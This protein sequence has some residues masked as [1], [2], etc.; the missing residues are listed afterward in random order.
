MIF[1]TTRRA[2]K[3]TEAKSTPLLLMLAFAVTAS[4]L[5]FDSC[6]K[7]A[8]IESRP[9]RSVSTA[10]VVSG[11]FAIVE[12][13]SA[14]IAANREIDI[15]PKVGGR[16]HTVA[17][18][19][20]ETVSAAQILFTI[21]PGDCEAQYRQAAAALQSA[22]A[23][24]TRT[25]DAGQEQQVIQAQAAVDMAHAAYSDAKSL[26]DKTK[27]L[28]DSGA[29]PKQQLDDVE[30]RYTSAEIQLESARKSLSLLR[31]KSGPQSDAVA[32][33]QVEEAQARLDLAKS[34]LDATIV[35]SPIEGQVSYRNVEPGEM[36]APSTLAF[37][38]IDERTLLAETGVS[39]RVVGKLRGGMK[40]KVLIDAIG[41]IPVDGIVESVSPAADPR[42][43][44]YQVRVRIG[45][46]TGRLRP[47]MLAKLE[48]PIEVRSDAILMPESAAFSV[49]GNDSAYVVA[50]GAA[51]LRRITLGESDG[52][53]VE[54]LAGL[55]AGETV[56]TGSQEFINDGEK[57]IAR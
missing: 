1:K 10:Q 29:I 7:R 20:G 44:L 26:Y 36:I 48:I 35:R 27:R 22:K 11:P 32:A 31:D 33:A 57:V 47:G 13:H 21:D 9:P 50:D 51:R 15:S 4:L 23:A 24:L 16:V 3:R 41:G 39:E 28:Y 30:T 5:G 43:L 56:V 53:N 40:I 54:V 2:A 18:D 42:T 12:E 14:R 38:V 37:I 55:A 25:S 45:N 19:L 34:Q 6:V 17:A 49:N 52:S 8:A 46:E